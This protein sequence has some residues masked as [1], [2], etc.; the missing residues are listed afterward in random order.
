M[1]PAEQQ[2]KMSES[3]KSDLK[4]STIFPYETRKSPE[5]TLF[6]I[7]TEATVDL[8]RRFYTETRA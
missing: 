6:E 7:E 8:Y 1:S 3:R 2:K 4:E 5:R